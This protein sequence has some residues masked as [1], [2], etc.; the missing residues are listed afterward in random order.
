MTGVTE[1]LF[2]CQMFMC[3][4]RPHRAEMDLGGG[5]FVVC[6]SLAGLLATSLERGLEEDREGVCFEKGS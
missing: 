3:L 1:K 4:L 5:F 6:V 2:M